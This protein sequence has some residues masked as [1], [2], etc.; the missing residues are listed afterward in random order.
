MGLWYARRTY[1]CGYRS[2]KDR[3]KE[4]GQTFRDRLPKPACRRKA[5]QQ[6][7]HAVA[8][9]LCT[10]CTVAAKRS[11]LVDE[12]CFVQRRGMWTGRAERERGE[13]RRPWT[14]RYAPVALS[15]PRFHQASALERRSMVL[16]EEK[17]AKHPQCDQ[18]DRTLRRACSILAHR[19]SL[20][21]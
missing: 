11:L 1:E 3:S 21:A 20:L 15:T 16:L 6:S 5:R 9:S 4:S 8:L 10:A 14:H 18:A 17:L 7:G 19:I 2:A 13:F 12:W